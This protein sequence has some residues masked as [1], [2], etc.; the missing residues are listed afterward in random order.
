MKTTSKNLALTL[1]LVLASVYYFSSQSREMIN[2]NLQIKEVEDKI[3]DP[4][5]LSSGSANGNFPAV[6]VE[7]PEDIAKS[8]KKI[9]NVDPNNIPEDLKAQLNAPPPELPEDLKRQLEMPPQELPE[10]LKAQL[11]ASPPPIPE[12]IQEALKTPSRVVTLDEV[13]GVQPE[14]NKE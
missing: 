14:D 2:S 5:N 11:N 3:K 7:V 6:N 8:A 4:I 9:E 1:F 10:D 13:N 12:D